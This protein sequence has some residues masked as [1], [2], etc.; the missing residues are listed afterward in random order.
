MR[1]EGIAVK[2][3]EKDGKT[4]FGSRS[5]EVTITGILEQGDDPVA[6]AK[7]LNDKAEAAL[8]GAIAAM[9]GEVPRSPLPDPAKE[10]KRISGQQRLQVQELLDK[11][12]PFI[13]KA[14]F[15]SP[16]AVAVA[17]ASKV[18]WA[19][20]VDAAKTALRTALLE[21]GVKT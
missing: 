13:G 21:Q 14:K 10:R 7:T 6:C 9:R 3:T 11:A 12:R 4:G 2:A 15:D 5:R 19:D 8:Q 18:Q 17:V 1:L 16:L 20:E